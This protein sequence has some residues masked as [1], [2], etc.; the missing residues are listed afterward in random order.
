GTTPPRCA[1]R[2]PNLGGDLRSCQFIH[3]FY[4]A[5][6]QLPSVI[7]RNL[8]VDIHDNGFR[9][10]VLVDG[11]RSQIAAVAR[12]ADSAERRSRAD[13]FVGVDPNHSG[14]NRIRHTMTALEIARPQSATE[15]V[16]G[17]VRDAD[18]FILI[19]ETRD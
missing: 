13:A 16:W 12:L 10:R 14:S 19:F 17:R 2:P 15:T 3:A 8:R 5:P 11:F 4:R 7:R 6:L 18:H 1:R 9:E